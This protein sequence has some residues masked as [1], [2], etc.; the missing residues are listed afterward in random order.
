MLALRRQRTA[1][2]ATEGAGGRSRPLRS[3]ALPTDEVDP[4]QPQERAASI[5]AAVCSPIEGI[6]YEYLS[7]VI[8]IELWPRSSCTSLGWTFALRSRV[9][10]VCLRS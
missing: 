4:P 7:K 3:T 10:A 8:A 2:T 1:R 6:Q 5:A 9:A